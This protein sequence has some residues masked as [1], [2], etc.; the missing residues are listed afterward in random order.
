MRAVTRQADASGTKAATHIMVDGEPIN[1]PDEIKIP[2]KPKKSLMQS[3]KETVGKGK[4][5]AEELKKVS[6]EEFDKF[7]AELKKHYETAGTPLNE[8]ALNKAKP[9][10]IGHT[11]AENTGKYT[12]NDFAKNTTGNRA[13]DIRDHELAK[14]YLKKYEALEVK[15]PKTAVKAETKK[16]ATETKKEVVKEA[17]KTAT[18]ITSTGKNSKKSKIVPRKTFKVAGT[19]KEA[20]LL[21]EE[22]SKL[23]AYP[24]SR[25]VNNPTTKSKPKLVATKKPLVTTKDKKTRITKKE[26]GGILKLQGG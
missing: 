13:I 19:E 24:K 26:E 17:E 18:K 8:E 25:E 21:K 10:D 2:S 9:T 7:K 3:A 5:K 1:I 16:V 15:A 11:K 14:K 20:K 23:D 22:K 12:L 4:D 6:T